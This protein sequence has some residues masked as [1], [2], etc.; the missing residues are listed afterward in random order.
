VQGLQVL[1]PRAILE[2]IAL[3][4]SPVSVEAPL[5]PG[6]MINP[7][8]DLLVFVIAI[9]NLAVGRGAFAAPGEIICRLAARMA[10]VT[11]ATV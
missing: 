2:L 11:P 4:S 9:E 5:G 6:S 3:R 8:D 7:T 1:N 10:N